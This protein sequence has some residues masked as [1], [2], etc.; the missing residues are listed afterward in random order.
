MDNT[1]VNKKS[2]LTEVMVKE[3]LNGSLVFRTRSICNCQYPFNLRN[4]VL[5]INNNIHIRTIIRC[6]RCNKGGNNG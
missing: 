2:D 6:K 1:F 5:V 3:H 4:A